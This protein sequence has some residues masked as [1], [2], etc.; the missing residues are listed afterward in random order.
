MATQ[1]LLNTILLSLDK[2][3][4]VGGLFCDLQAFDCVN[5]DKL[6]AKLD[7]GIYGNANNEFLFK[8]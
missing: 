4:Y 2:K 7:Y 1:A 8:K 5:H 6:L 3:E